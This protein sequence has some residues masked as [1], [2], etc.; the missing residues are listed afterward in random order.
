[1]TASPATFLAR[2]TT[3]RAASGPSP[4]RLEHDVV[5]LFDDLR[6]PLLRYLLSSRVPLADAEDIVQEAFLLLFR[7]LRAGKP[8]TN[9]PA[10]LF[11]VAH[12]LARKHHEATRRAASLQFAPDQV[13]DD[14]NPAQRFEL[15]ERRDQLLAVVHALPENDQRCLTLRAEGLRYREIAQILGLSLGTVANSLARTLARL[16][17]KAVAA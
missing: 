6:S 16:E 8:R 5:A 12:N 4:S 13:V 15:L 10:W 3:A 11:G 17:R 2:F 1:M 7:H 14:P 9:L